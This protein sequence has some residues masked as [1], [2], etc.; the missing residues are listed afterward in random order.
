MCVSAVIDKTN[1]EITHNRTLWAYW[2]LMDGQTGP[3][4]PVMIGSACSSSK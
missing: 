4:V 2:H 3:A 1:D